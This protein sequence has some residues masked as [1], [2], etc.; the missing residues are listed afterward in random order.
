MSYLR[1]SII[2]IIWGILGLL[3]DH[4]LFVAVK[5]FYLTVF[6]E[7]DDITHPSLYWFYSRSILLF[8]FVAKN[9]SLAVVYWTKA[10]NECELFFL[11]QKQDFD[12]SKCMFVIIGPLV[13]NLPPKIPI[14]FFDPSLYQKSLFL[15]R[16]RYK[17]LTCWQYLLPKPTHFTEQGV[18]P[19]LNISL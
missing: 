14:G 2:P 5:F 9:N 15:F 13:E 16:S 17:K 6:L 18:G 12:I 19:P 10:L 1:V 4:V 8:S 11:L 3:P 7:M